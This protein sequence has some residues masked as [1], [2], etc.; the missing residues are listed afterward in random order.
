MSK[1]LVV[2]VVRQ[3]I[4][5]LY[6]K[7]LRKSKKYHVHNE[8][9]GIKLGDMVTIVKTRPLSKTKHYKVGEKL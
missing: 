9:P 2:E 7:I 1:T 4:H 6:K 3:S 8:D 5:P